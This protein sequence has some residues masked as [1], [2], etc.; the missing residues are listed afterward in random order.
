MLI[1]NSGDRAARHREKTDAVTGF[2]L[3][4]KYSDFPTINRLFGFKNHRGLYDLLNKLVDEGT[5]KKHIFGSFRLWSIAGNDLSR[6]S[7]ETIK[8][9]LAGQN[10]RFSFEATGASHWTDSAD[11]VLPDELKHRPTAI[12][13]LPDGQRAA[14]EI[15]T[16]IKTMARYKELVK[17]H[18]VA[19]KQQAWLTVFFICPNEQQRNAVRMLV[20]STENITI[21]GRQYTVEAKHFTIFR[22]I[23]LSE[24]G[25][26]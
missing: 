18:L 16:S 23:T 5:L 1:R 11:I 8:A 3:R 12:V 26:L 9:K 25:T 13:T 21:D 22:F 7:P 19:R 15:H 2:L 6:L 14:L 17:N 4:E 20:H 10:A 24:I